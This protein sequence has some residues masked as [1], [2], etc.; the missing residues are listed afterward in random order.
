VIYI[1]RTITDIEDYIESD[2]S[3]V[4]KFIELETKK[5]TNEKNVDVE[6]MTLLDNLKTKK[7]PSALPS[8]NIFKFNVNKKISF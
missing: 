3:L 7:I 8:S 2:T 1:E 6:T 4:G 5:G